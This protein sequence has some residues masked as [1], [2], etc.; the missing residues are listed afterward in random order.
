MVSGVVSRAQAFSHDYLPV[1]LAA[2]LL[3]RL[4][5]EL[6]S[7]ACLEGTGYWWIALFSCINRRLSLIMLI[8]ESVMEEV[9]RGL[10]MYVYSSFVSYKY[11]KVL[12]H[13]LCR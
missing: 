8:Y 12:R 3:W 2:G 13:V 11:Y 4:Y 1:C 9:G 6:D 10:F 5:W 7:F